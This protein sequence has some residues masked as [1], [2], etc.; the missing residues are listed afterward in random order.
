MKEHARAYMAFGLSGK[1][2]QY[3]PLAVWYML[4]LVCR[5]GGLSFLIK[6]GNNKWL[7]NAATYKDFFF[8]TGQLPEMPVVTGPSSAA[9]SGLKGPDKTLDT[10]RWVLRAVTGCWFWGVCEVCPLTC[11]SREAKPGGTA[12]L[13]CVQ[14]R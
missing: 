3:L 7:G 12:V 9:G 4:V 10:D 5:H 14:P 13:I 1:P 2:L 11:V 8:S 6:T